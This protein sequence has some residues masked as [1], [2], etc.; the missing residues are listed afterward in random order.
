MGCRRKWTN[1]SAQQEGDD[2]EEKYRR[3]K[4]CRLPLYKRPAKEDDGPWVHDRDKATSF[5][6]LFN[7]ALCSGIELITDLAAG[8]VLTVFAGWR[9]IQTP[10]DIPNYFA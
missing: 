4:Y 2:E 1:G 10:A 7:S 9:G 3:K 5:L 6:T 8:T